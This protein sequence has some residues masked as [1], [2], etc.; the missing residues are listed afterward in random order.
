M[1]VFKSAHDVLEFAIE[2]EIEAEKFYANLAEKAR[3][4]GMREAFLAF[5]KE[6]HG[7]QKKLQAIQQGKLQNLQTTRP[8]VDLKLADYLVHVIPSDDMSYQDALILAM[9]RE[10]AAYRLYAVL[11]ERMTD[12]DLKQTFQTLA[13]E[14]AKHKMRFEV[15]YDEVVLA[16]N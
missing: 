4:P 6:E 9:K 16:E 2:R 10:K 14:E 5:A 3:T 11:A 12:P 1:T 15:E 7:H 8:L 13:N